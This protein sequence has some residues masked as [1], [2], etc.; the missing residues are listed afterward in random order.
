M[1]TGMR[2]LRGLAAVLGI[3]VAAAAGAPDEAAAQSHT[4]RLDA[5]LA[6]GG[7]PIEDSLDIAVWQVEGEG[8]PAVVAERHAAPAEVKLAPGRYRVVAEYRTART[9]QDILV[10]DQGAQRHVINL[11]AGEIELSLLPELRAKPIAGPLEWEIRRYARGS[12]A[13]RK[14][15]AIRAGR[16]QLLLSEGWYE[17]Q[18]KHGGE[19][20]EHVVEVAAG[21]RYDYTIVMDR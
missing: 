19:A 7:A 3:A 1:F 5:V 15:A 11:K 2:K 6:S 13:G 17:V 12:K 4:V 20:I 8:A 9:V 10:A 18:V 16:P 14:I 21:Q